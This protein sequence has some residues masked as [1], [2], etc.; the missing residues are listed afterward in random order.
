MK[1]TLN[2]KEYSIKFGYK[3]TVKSGIIK[4]LAKVEIEGENADGFESI[5]GRLLILP[6]LL[7]VGTQVHHSDEFGYNI[8]TNEGYQ[9]QVDKAFD[10]LEK[11]LEN[12]ENSF[13]ELFNSFENELL[14][15]SFLSSLFQ[16]AQAE[17]Q[18][19]T[20]K[21]TKKN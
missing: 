5:E 15:D 9:D 21:T 2:E 4:K 20:K 10:M 6:E 16:S 11:W 7:V 19:T 1:I 18:K 13:I 17:E 3:A 8:D 14:N 12:K